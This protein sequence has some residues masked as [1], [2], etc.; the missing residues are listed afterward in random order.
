[1]EVVLAD[2]VVCSEPGARSSCPSSPHPA[3]TRATAQVANTHRI[4][5]VLQTVGGDGSNGIWRRVHLVPFTEK[6]VEP[7]LE[8]HSACFSHSGTALLTWSAFASRPERLVEAGEDRASGWLL[9]R[10]RWR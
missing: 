1:V 8:A 10:P 4:G 7:E 2:V 5:R 6:I 9:L 3:S